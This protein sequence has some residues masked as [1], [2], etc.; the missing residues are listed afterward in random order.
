MYDAI[1]RHML[2][3]LKPDQPMPPEWYKDAACVGTDPELFFPLKDVTPRSERDRDEHND[4]SQAALIKIAKRVCNGDPATGRPACPVLLE[5]L[6]YAM[7]HHE[8]HGIWGGLTFPERNQLRRAR[9]ERRQRAERA[10]FRAAL[11]A[12]RRD[13]A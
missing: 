8:K 2:A 13:S 9:Y 7:A 6:A 12:A 10:A 11:R 1:A 5:C 3:S 4:H